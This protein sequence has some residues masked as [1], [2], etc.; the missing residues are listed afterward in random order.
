MIQKYIDTSQEQFHDFMKLP[1][2][3]SFQMMNLLKFKKKVEGTEISGENAYNEYMAA[4][5]PFFKSTSAKIIYQ[6]KPIFNLIGPKG[7]L[8][9]DKILIVEYGSKQEFIGM[10]TQEGYPKEMRNRAIANSRLIVCT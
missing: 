6:G 10:I 4:V 7:S 3:G 1:I 8:E 5:V 9:W 2:E